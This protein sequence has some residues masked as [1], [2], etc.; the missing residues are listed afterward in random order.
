M[1][2][3]D[4]GRSFL[5]SFLVNFMLFCAYGIIS[6]KEA[7]EESKTSFLRQPHVCWEPGF[8]AIPVLADNDSSLTADGKPD[9]W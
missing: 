8:R 7:Q 9:N 3:L 4:A 2:A 6:R 1:K 5:D